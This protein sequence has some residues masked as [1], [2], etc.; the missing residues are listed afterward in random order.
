MKIHDLDGQRYFFL[1]FHV[2]DLQMV[3]DGGIWTFEQSLL[4]YNKLETM[5]VF[6]S[7]RI[8]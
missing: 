7:K 4:I 6:L 1:F 8:L 2:L 5:W 3:I